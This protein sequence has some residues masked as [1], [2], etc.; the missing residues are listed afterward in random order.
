MKTTQEILSIVDQSIQNGKT[1]E[2]RQHAREVTLLLYRE[3]LDSLAEEVRWKDGQLFL[4]DMPLRWH[5]AGLYA[6]YVSPHLP[7]SEWPVIFN[8]ATL[9]KA[10]TQFVLDT[11][12]QE[13]RT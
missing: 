10:L 12:Q 3:G 9:H 7:R 13:N 8:A 5:S 2:A 4:G 11:T 1:A 6:Q